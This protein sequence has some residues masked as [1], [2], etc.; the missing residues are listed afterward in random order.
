MRWGWIL[1]LWLLPWMAVAEI[2]EVKTMREVSEVMQAL[3]PED[4]ALFDIDMVLLQPDDPAFQMPNLT[5]HRTIVKRVLASIDAGQLDALFTLMALRSQ[6]LLVDGAVLG[7]LCDLRVRGVPAMALT[8]NFHGPFAEVSSLAEWKRTR[9]IQAGIDFAPLAPRKGE[10]LFEK[11]AS[12]RGYFPLY[13]N[14]LFFSNGSL[15]PKGAAL[16]AFLQTLDQ[17]PRRISFVDDRRENLDS[18]E[19]ALKEAFPEI[20]FE[21][22][23]YTGANDYPSQ[24]VTADYFEARWKALLDEMYQLN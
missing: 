21:G 13:T 3:E 16:V 6:S 14:G 5:R 17:R 22:L 18:M 15:C 11:L 12:Q 1:G 9:L 2:Q 7:V 4:L 23:H 20:A 10:I 19:A 8:A 24:P